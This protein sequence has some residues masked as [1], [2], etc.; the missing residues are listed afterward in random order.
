ME[1]SNLLAKMIEQ[2]QKSGLLSDEQVLEYIHEASDIVLFSIARG[3]TTEHAA[4]AAQFCD[5]ILSSYANRTSFWDQFGIEYPAGD[6]LVFELGRDYLLKFDAVQ[7]ASS[8]KRM[9]EFILSLPGDCL[10]ELNCEPE[11]TSTYRY[12]PEK[13]LGIFEQTI[14]IPSILELLARNRGTVLLWAAGAITGAMCG[15]KFNKSAQAVALTE[16]E[17]GEIIGERGLIRER[18]VCK[19]MNVSF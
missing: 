11:F 5:H 12:S 18:W 19:V 2:E 16:D 3:D 7:I 14:Q 8:A 15:W 10:L 1:I 13:P 6:P 9:T 17:L 4:D